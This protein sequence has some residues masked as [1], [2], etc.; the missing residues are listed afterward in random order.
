MFDNV[1]DEPKRETQCR[2]ALKCCVWLLNS[3]VIQL[4]EWEPNLQKW[5][6]SESC[7]C[8]CHEGRCGEM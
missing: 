7:H 4:S 3:F 2:M 6:A 5:L 1:S 8:V